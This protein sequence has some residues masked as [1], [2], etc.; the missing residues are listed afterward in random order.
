M[1]PEPKDYFEAAIKEAEICAATLDPT[2]EQFKR[3]CESIE[4]LHRTRRE[5]K[6]HRFGVDSE[7]LAKI[8]GSLA[9][10]LAVL[11]YEN[12]HVVVSKAFQLIPR[13]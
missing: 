8:A 7:E 13:I 3:V 12:A 9:G 10:I 6:A 2:D 5:D 1:E 11:A 4:I